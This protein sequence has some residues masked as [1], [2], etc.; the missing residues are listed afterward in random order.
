VWSHSNKYLPDSVFIYMVGS[1]MIFETIADTLKILIDQKTVDI[2]DFKVKY[3]VQRLID[4]KYAIDI[5]VGNWTKL[6]KYVQEGRWDYITHKFTSTYQKE[7][8]TAL[9]IGGSLLACVGGYF[10]S[11]RKRKNNVQPFTKNSQNA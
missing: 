8:I 4:N 10:F 1:D 2:K 7:F 3:L 11:Y 9:F 6:Y 5:P